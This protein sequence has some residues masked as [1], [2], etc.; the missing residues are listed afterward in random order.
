MVAPTSTI[1]LK[2]SSFKDIPI[3]IRSKDEVLR[4]KDNI[5]APIS[6][7]ALNYSFDITPHQ[8]ITAIITE[9]GVIYPP[10]EDNIKKTC[11]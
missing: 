5:I 9:K 2:A 1:D 4:C 6:S 8:N 7:D 11:L 10:F 3:E